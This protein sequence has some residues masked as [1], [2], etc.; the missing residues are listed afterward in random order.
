MNE[1]IEPKNVDEADEAL[2]RLN[3]FHDGYVAGIEIKFENYRDMSKGRLS[4]IGNADK[5][6]ILTVDNYPINQFVKVEFID[7][8]SFEIISEWHVGP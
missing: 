7:V 1:R 8:T 2:E 3:R 5:T 6:I 4:G